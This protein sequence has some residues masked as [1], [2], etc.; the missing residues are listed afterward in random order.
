[1]LSLN[2]PST[3]LERVAM[4]SLGDP[5]TNPYHPFFSPEHF[6]EDWG[7]EEWFFNK[8]ELLSSL[9]NIESNELTIRRLKRQ[10]YV[11]L[12][13]RNMKIEM[14]GRNKAGHNYKIFDEFLN[15]FNCDNDDAKYNFIVKFYTEYPDLWS[16]DEGTLLSNA[17]HCVNRFTEYCEPRFVHGDHAGALCVYPMLNDIPYFQK[18]VKSKKKS[19]LFL[20]LEERYQ[21]LDALGFPNPKTMEPFVFQT[22]TNPSLK[23]TQSRRAKLLKT[24]KRLHQLEEEEDQ[25][26]PTE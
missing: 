7:S 13:T 9:K 1:M 2:T 15:Y 3:N 22:K 25:L 26:E 8:Q 21:Q 6:P 16:E 24:K 20:T 4:E 18:G 17:A 5:K 14:E 11:D 19:S 23:K 12:V 10:L